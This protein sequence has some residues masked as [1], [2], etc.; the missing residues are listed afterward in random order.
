[1]STLTAIILASLA[2]GVLSCAL[3]AVALWLS[4]VWVNRLVALAVGAMLGAVFLD[5][6][7]SA[8][9]LSNAETIFAWVLAGILFFFVLEKFV[10]W[11]HAHSHGEAE[12]AMTHQHHHHHHVHEV[13][14]QE[15]SAGIMILVGD[16]FHNFCD[17]VLIAG[18]FLADFRLG[19]VT[20]A[21][22]IAH[23]LPQEVG[24][25]IVLLNAGFSRKKAFLYNLL[26]SLAMLVGGVLGYYTLQ[27][28]KN[29]LPMALSFAAASMIYVAIADL[30]PSLHRK[31]KLRDA[32]EQ[33]LLIGLGIGFIVAI[34]HV[35][36]H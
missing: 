23:E 15:H 4:H 25:F 26:S 22:M 9:A 10:L 21:A 28:A 32:I 7:P 14:G 5:V 1:M 3:A 12:E 31:L 34:H 33:M 8:F 17:G 20:S 36:E 27:A 18:A 11:R 6:L 30:I 16:T 13:S 35:L 29:L 19:V 24:D 2:G